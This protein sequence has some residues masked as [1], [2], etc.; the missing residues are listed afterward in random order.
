[1]Y[2]CVGRMLTTHDHTVA[3]GNQRITIDLV[4]HAGRPLTQGVYIMQVDING[5]S[6]TEK[7]VKL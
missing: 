1:M 2:D 3:S 5:R 7:I 4:D 6:V